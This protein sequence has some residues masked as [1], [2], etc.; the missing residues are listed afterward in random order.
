MFSFIHGF[1]NTAG[2]VQTKSILLGQ[3]VKHVELRLNGTM[4]YNL[5][6]PRFPYQTA[7]PR[8]PGNEVDVA[9]C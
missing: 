6:K 2:P 4:T 1:I 7:N 8:N 5:F 9:Q 3:H